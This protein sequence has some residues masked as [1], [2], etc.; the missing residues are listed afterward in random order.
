LTSIADAKLPTGGCPGATKD[1]D[2]K[3]LSGAEAILGNLLH[4]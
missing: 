3:P 1:P 4:G 2:L